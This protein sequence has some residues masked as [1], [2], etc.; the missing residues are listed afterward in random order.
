MGRGPVTLTGN[1]AIFML[2]RWVFVQLFFDG[3]T[4]RDSAPVSYLLFGSRSGGA[5]KF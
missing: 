1:D 3:L 5:P 4:I 2:S